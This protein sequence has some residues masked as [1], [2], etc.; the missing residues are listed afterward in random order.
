MQIRSFS[1]D[2]QGPP[3]RSVD[4]SLM[5]SLLKG[6]KA[7]GRHSMADL[8]WA[9]VLVM[10]KNLAHNAG[11]NVVV[12]R[13]PAGVALMMERETA[14]RV[15][16]RNHVLHLACDTVGRFRHAYDVPVEAVVAA[17][18]DLEMASVFSWLATGDRGL[19][20]ESMCLHLFP[21]SRSYFDEEPS[22]LAHP[23]DY[24][25]FARCAGFLEAVPTATRRLVELRA[26]GPNWENLI[27]AWGDL[28]KMYDR[29]D[30]AG[31]TGLIKAVTTRS[32]A[33]GEVKKPSAC[34]EQSLTI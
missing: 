32:P 16:C 9:V 19:S 1:A 33:R 12:L 3:E 8:P 28:T 29:R 31:V 15:E 18:D 34:D 2:I 13:R 4:I 27:S 20:S 17:P 6:M 11:E 5:L 30:S 7:L 26:I 10:G 14:Y 24:A 23:L 22:R 25:D 21:E